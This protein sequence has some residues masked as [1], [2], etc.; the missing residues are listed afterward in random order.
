MSH[1]H[2]DQQLCRVHVSQTRG[3][4]YTNEAVLEAMHGATVL[5][6]QS[7]CSEVTPERVLQIISKHYP[8]ISFD[9][10]A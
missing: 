3:A 5:N 8:D 2:S 10:C 6:N 9:I 1:P 7:K 4:S